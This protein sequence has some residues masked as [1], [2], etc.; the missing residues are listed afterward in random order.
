MDEKTGKYRRGVYI[1][2]PY[3]IAKG[4][5]NDIKKFRTTFDYIEKTIEPQINQFDIED[6]LK[7]ERKII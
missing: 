5:W 3:I 4:K 2:N 7:E 1:V 6:Y